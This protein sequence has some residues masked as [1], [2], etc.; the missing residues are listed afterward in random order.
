MYARILAYPKATAFLLYGGTELY[1][2]DQI[3]FIPVT[4]F[5]REAIHLFFQPK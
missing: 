4:D 5:F 3:H 2:E 1:T